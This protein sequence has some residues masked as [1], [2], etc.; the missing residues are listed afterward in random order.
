MMNSLSS[1]G[2]LT[3]WLAVPGAEQTFLHFMV[4]GNELY[5]RLFFEARV[6]SILQFDV[7][8]PCTLV[9]RSQ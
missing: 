2:Q 6:T 1:V 3:V 8:G 4:I 7:A 9:W 5:V